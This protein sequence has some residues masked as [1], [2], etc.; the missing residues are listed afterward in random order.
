[1][2]LMHGKMYYWSNTNSGFP[3]CIFLNLNQFL[4]SVIIELLFK[5]KF[6]TFL[7]IS[8]IEI[9]VTKADSW[10]VLSRLWFFFMANLK[11]FSFLPFSPS[12]FLTSSFIYLFFIYGVT[13]VAV[14]TVTSGNYEADEPSK[15][16]VSIHA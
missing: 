13:F 16:N 6:H 9:Y 12:V 2:P 7:C 11:Y 8:F 1:M 10:V 15:D 14:F 5:Q 3:L 4:S